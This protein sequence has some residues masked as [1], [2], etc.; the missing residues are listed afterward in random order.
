MTPTERRI[1]DEIVLG[2]PM[3]VEHYMALCLNHYYASRDPLGAA[4]DFTTAP[5]ISQMF[6]E[7]I[8]LWMAECWHMAGSPASAAWV[9]LG[10]GRGTLTMDALRAAKRVPAFIDALDVHLVETSPVLR[11]KQ[12]EMLQSFGKAPVWHD[13]VVSLPED[14]PLFVVANEFFDALPIQQYVADGGQWRRRCVGLDEEGEALCFGLFPSEDIVL[15]L[16]PQGGAVLEIP[17]Q[18]ADLMRQLARRLVKQ[19]GVVLA[20]D[21]G[22]GGPAYGDS[23]QALRHHK[24]VS[25]LDNP[26]EADLTAHVGFQYLADAAHQE[27]MAVHGLV[28]QGAFLQRLGLDIRAETLMRAAPGEAENI[29]LAR[30]RLVGTGPGE[31]GEL[32]KVMALSCPYMPEL[33]GLPP[34]PAH[35]LNR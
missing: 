7:L 14:R 25:A 15:P 28:S 13:S 10:P 31:M 12:R 33:P 29:S 24:F 32:F 35:R 1:R 3:G 27:G 26:G 9:E 20:I 8:G 22:Y 21:Y 11:E 23:L 6:G 30:A 18:G 4:G 34:C 16:P 5:E 19:G 17:A 2:G